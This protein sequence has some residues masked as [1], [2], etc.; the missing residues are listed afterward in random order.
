MIAGLVLAGGSGRRFGGVEKALL[1]L[2][3]RPL[4]AHVVARLAPQVGALAISGR[5]VL[6]PY[7]PGLP[8]L[9]DGAFAGRGPLAGLLAG[10]EWAA[11]IGAEAMLSMP[12]DTPFFPDDLAS[13]LAPAPSV[14]V[15]GGRV[16]HLVALWPLAAAAAVRAR[17]AGGG[18][19]VALAGV[20]CREVGFAAA[21][22]WFANINTPEA[23]AA[24]ERRLRGAA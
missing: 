19:A 20:G 18:G 5:G 7:V 14:A 22:D 13:R 15:C 2:G 9:D 24:A 17:L 12:V 4:I 1:R 3:G 11:S 6:A 10:L 23:L 8:I 21:G 16:H